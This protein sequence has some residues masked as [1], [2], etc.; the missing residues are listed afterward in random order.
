[1]KPREGTLTGCIAVTLLFAASFA[2]LRALHTLNVQS[3]KAHSQDQE[4]LYLPNGAALELISFGY[5]NALANLLWFRTISYFGE[6]YATDKNYFWLNHMCELVSELSPH[7][8]H[9]YQFCSNMLSWE[10]NAPEQS[11]ELLSKGIERSPH[12]WRLY[13][14]RAITYLYF[15]KSTERARDDFVT[16]SR[17]E[18]APVL[19]KRLAAKTLVE[20]DSPS[21]AIT[22]LETLLAEERDPSARKALA[23]RLVQLRKN[24]EVH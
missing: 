22:L 9:V 16:A 8:A 11:I 21:A 17:L 14:Y 1:M 2:G 4:T 15:L 3:S 23:E 7:A 13:Y 24:Q 10:A 18:G 5:K 20:L 6:H 12:D 19:V